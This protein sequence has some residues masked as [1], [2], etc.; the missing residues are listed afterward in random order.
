MLSEDI[1]VIM[2]QNSNKVQ[3]RRMREINEIN[4]CCARRQKELVER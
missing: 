3:E 1:M 4:C 2:Q